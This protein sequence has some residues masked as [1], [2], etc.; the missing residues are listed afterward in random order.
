MSL[1]SFRD[2]LLDSLSNIFN[3]AA[4]TNTYKMLTAISNELNITDSEIDNLKEGTLIRRATEDELDLH[5]FTLNV[6]RIA[7]EVDEDY[8]VRILDS[9]D[10]S[11]VTKQNLI[12]LATPYSLVTPKIEE[13]VKDRWWVGSMRPGKQT[14]LASS[15]TNTIIRAASGI[16]QGTIP[17]CW[18]TTDYAHTGTNYCSGCSFTNDGSGALIYLTTPVSGADV[19]LEISYT[20]DQPSSGANIDWTPH[21]YL[22]NDVIIR[23]RSCSNNYLEIDT[24]PTYVKILTNM[25]PGYVIYS[26]YFNIDD[27]IVYSWESTVDDSFYITLDETK[28]TD[29]LVTDEFQ[30]ASDI[31]QVTVN[32]DIANVVG[33]Y[34]ATDTSHSLIN[35]ASDNNFKGR[36]IYLNTSL[37]TKTNVIVTYH[38]YSIRDYRSLDFL[39]FV[40][41]G[42]EDLRFTIEVQISQD[43]EKYGTFK[44]SEKRWGQLQNELTGT[45]GQLIDIAKAAGI[46]S[47]V[48]LVSKGTYYGA[49]DAIYSQVLYGGSYY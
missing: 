32:N 35:Y 22:N 42:F 4:S 25:L 1:E 2:L 23:H 6:Q 30:V 9:Y 13:Y 47:S 21:S 39:K 15:V 10:G 27:G 38:K 41:T 44:Y 45:L 11:Y 43:F 7:N 8:R 49:E 14:E 12:S 24:Q 31:T 48:I 33:V 37:P 17:D 40:K 34:L 28:R 3:K 19:Q 20:P 36:T 16:L 5:G 26:S 46:K 29:N 18:A